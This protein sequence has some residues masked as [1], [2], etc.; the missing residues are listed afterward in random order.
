MRYESG[1]LVRRSSRT[2]RGAPSSLLR[3]RS[4]TRCEE[5]TLT[6]MTVTPNVGAAACISSSWRT[7]EAFGFQRKATRE[8]VGIGSLR[9][10]QPLGT[11][12]RAND[13]V[14]GDISSRSSEAWHEPGAYGIADRDHND[15]NSWWWL[16][17][18]R[19]LRACRRLQ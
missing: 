5:L 17:W 14:A 1:G 4:R 12:V 6:E 7:L 13:G 11:D 3:M 9:I 15:G 19:S 2:H 8:T 16:A 18:P 10:L